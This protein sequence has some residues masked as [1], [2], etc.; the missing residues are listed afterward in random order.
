MTKIN[1]RTALAARAAAALA[2]GA[3]RAQAW[4][5]NQNEIDKWETVIATGGVKPDA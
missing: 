4:P 3:A 1:R 5:D 2:P